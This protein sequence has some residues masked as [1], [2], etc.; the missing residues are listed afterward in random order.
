MQL[1][2]V[3]FASLV[4]YLRDSLDIEALSLAPIA[5]GIFGIGFLA[6]ALRRVAGQNRA[7]LLTSGGVGLMRLMEQFSTAPGFD[8]VLSAAGAALFLLFIPIAL[9]KARTKG[10]SGT[11]ELGLALLLGLAADTSIHIGA[12]TLD[13]SWQPGIIPVAI[14]VLLAAGLAW[15]L[16]SDKPNPES[17]TS[18]DTGWRCALGLM[19][20]G[21]WLFLQMQVFQNVARVSAL[22]GWETP[23]AGA[24]VVLG[25]GLGVLCASWIVG[26]ESKPLNNAVQAG[27]L[28][29]ASL[30]IPEPLGLMALPIL[31]IGQVCSLVLLVLLFAQ[32]GRDAVRPGLARTTVTL[33][34][35]QIMFVLIVFA[36]YVTYDIPLGFRAQV[37]LPISAA[38]VGILAA[39][40]ISGPPTPPERKVGLSPTIAALLMIAA[41]LVLALV[42]IRPQA[43]FPHPTNASVRVIDYNVHNGFNTSG[44]LDLEALATII[45]DSEADVVG[46]QE[47]SRGWLI[48][49]STDML[50][51]LSQRLGMPY[52]SGPT[53]DAQWGNAVLSRYPIVR[54]ETFPL[55][56]EELLIRRGYIVAEIDIGGGT[57]TL[58][59]THLAHRGST[60]NAARE[61]QAAAIANAWDGA[62]NTVIVGDM[63]AP[64]EADS[65]LTLSNAGLVNVAAEICHQPV[66][67]SPA[68]DPHR[69]IDYIW[70]SP[71]LWASECEV[72]QTLASDHLPVVA[73]ITLP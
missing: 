59:D 19:A 43:T 48:W 31:L 52:V 7:I 15:A 62:A 13:L 1:L 9:G 17:S 40:S 16:I 22:T 54:A 4:G 60:N 30:I 45:E 55:P 23:G 20:F 12:R 67:T 6:A 49:S 44:R 56:T 29:T 69:Q 32:S 72:G 36:Y 26:R 57:I 41:P 46:L 61:M 53:A 11:T 33:G 37:L 34:V 38:L 70:I 28:L 64:P 68:T 66:L 21:P 71:D 3:L 2:R 24:L 27:L 50:T 25:N 65:M 35:G 73:T 5:L 51:W 63:N 14:I 8:L 58:I 42:W 39:I 10:V 47:I 18:G